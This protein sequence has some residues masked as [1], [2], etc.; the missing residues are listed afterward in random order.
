MLTRQHAGLGEGKNSSP[1]QLMSELKSAPVH[2]IGAAQR[3]LA[4]VQVSD[5]AE[6][7][8]HERLY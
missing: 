6:R 3:A 1:P 2:Q 7:C 8:P 5:I 4:A